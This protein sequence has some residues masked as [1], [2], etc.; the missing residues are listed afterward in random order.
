MRQRIVTLSRRTVRPI[1]SS[2]RVTIRSLRFPRPALQEHS[3]EV[4]EIAGTAPGPR[5]YVM[6]G[7]HVNEVAAIA[8]AYRL[9]GDFAAVPF[10]GQV[11]ILPVVNRPA[12]AS[13][14]Q[15][16]CPIDNKNINFSF[17]GR[18]DGSFSEA[19]AHAILRDWAGD[20]DVLIDLHGGDLCEN[21]ARFTVVPIT[22]DAAFD[23]N[24]LALAQAFDPTIIVR[25]PPTALNAPGRS[26]SGRA[27][28][29]R[30][31]VFAEAGANGLL[32]EVSIRFHADGVL[33]VAAALGMLPDRTIAGQGKKTAKPYIADS[34]HWLQAAAEGWC[35]YHVEPAESVRRG[36]LL[37]RITDYAG[38]VVQTLEAPI[39]GIVLWRCT[40]PLVIPS[41]DLFGIGGITSDRKT[42]HAAS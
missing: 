38:Q 30:Y 29:R 20:A 34:Y 40:H 14:A 15:Y 9:I 18:P 35:D 10:C 21:V 16:V 5:L 25:L 22:G 31:A 23:E 4:Y 12:V 2:K 7:M 11:S 28:L 26:C 33:N 3:W 19:L 37:A 41:S 36:D 27:R 32:D 13:R 42:S 6:A 24:N 17:P 8:A 1:Q 39:D